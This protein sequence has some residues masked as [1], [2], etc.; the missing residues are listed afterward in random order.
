VHAMRPAME[1]PSFAQPTNLPV[2]EP[3]EGN[4]TCRTCQAA[5]SYRFERAR[6]YASYQAALVRAIVLLKFERVEPPGAWFAARLAEIAEHEGNALATDLVVPV[7]LHRQ[8]ERG[9]NQ[10]HL[11]ARP[12]ANRLKLR[13]QDAC[14]CAFTPGRTSIF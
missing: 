14:L 4:L 13:Y 12:L 1:I 10:A 2:E 8:R 5:G 7:P 9:Y 11:I 6:S 3:S